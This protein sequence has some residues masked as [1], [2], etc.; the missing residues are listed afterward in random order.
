M[1]GYF[2][3]PQYDDCYPYEYTKINKNKYNYSLFLDYNISPNM[4]ADMKVCLENDNSSCY[5][6][7]LN[8]EATLNKIPENFL[9]ITEIDN[10][11]K[12]INRHLSY[13]NDKQFQGCFDNTEGNNIIVNPQL[14]NRE[15]APTNM[16]KFENVLF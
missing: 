6:C 12:G 14:C 11:L 2:T 1:S 10:D 5:T 15:I 4:K 13:C 9:K 3:R 16:K 8:N 7:K